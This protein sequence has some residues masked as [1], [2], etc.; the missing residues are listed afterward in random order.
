MNCGKNQTNVAK[1]N[2]AD[3]GEKTTNW[4]EKK[5]R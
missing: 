3:P 1:E 5:Y 4:K 2:E